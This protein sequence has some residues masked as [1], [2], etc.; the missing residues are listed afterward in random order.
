[1]NFILNYN[2]WRNLSESMVQLS[3]V[4]LP[5]LNSDHD[6][7]QNDFVNQALIDDINAAAKSVGITATITTAKT[8][9]SAHAKSGRVSR[10]M[11]GTGVDV[12]ILNG[13]GAGGASNPMNGNAKFRELGNKLKDALISMGYVWNT[14][15]GKDKAVL[16][17]TNLGGN[18]YN[19][20]HIS[21]RVGAS[22]LP[23]VAPEEHS[24]VAQPTLITLADIKSGKKL[25][26]SGHVGEV[27]GEIQKKLKEKGF[28]KKEPNNTYDKDMYNWVKEF[29]VSSPNPIR[30]DGI[31]GPFTYAKLY[32][33]EIKAKPTGQIQL[34]YIN[35]FEP[36][37]RKKSEETK[38]PFEWAISHIAMESGWG[39]SSPGYNFMGIKGNSQNGQLLW[40]WEAF[41]DV[42]KFDKFP[43]KDESTLKVKDG[44]YQMKV[45]DW[46]RKFNSM[47][48]SI[49]YYYS[50]LLNKRYKPA[51]DVYLSSEGTPWS[52]GLDIL[53]RGYA[54]ANSE[55]Y[56]NR[57]KQLFN[58]NIEQNL[59]LNPPFLG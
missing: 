30:M 44:K 42:S 47:E 34:D 22:S 1:V 2:K 45:K 27:V 20:L 37:L 25:L 24:H 35:A 18:H 50:L 52:Y 12:A 23:S 46:F 32:G 40:T 58:Q 11:D 4:N 10:H 3:T 39:K 15:S 21:N 5:N 26:K 56:A 17:Q 19:H 28:Y 41:N 49:D 29:Q 54:T 43:E 6:G 48:E 7:T 16:W 31:V 53:R 13:I 55:V 57:V 59:K 14:E 9:H 36:I 51:L 8:G 38:I 33:E